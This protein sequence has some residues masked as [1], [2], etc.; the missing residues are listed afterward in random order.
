MQNVFNILKQIE[1]TSSRNE[2]EQILENN[3]QNILFKD[4]IQFIFNPYIVT[5]ISSKKI[6]KI[7]TPKVTTQKIN[8]VQDLIKYLSD[9]NTGSD[10]NISQVLTFIQSQLIELQEDYIKLTTKSFKIGITAKTINKT[11]GKNFIPEFNVQ[12]AD[13]YFDCENKVK[14]EFII[15]TK[16]DG[17]RIVAIKQ[18]E[19]NIKFFSRQ[20]QPIEDLVEIE[21]ELKRLPVGYVYDGELL[22]TNIEKL[23]SK[24][25]YRKTMQIG[26]KDGIKKGLEFHMFDIITI[27]SFTKGIDKTP[28]FKRKELLHNILSKLDLKHIVEVSMLYQGEDKE[29]VIKLLNE[30][31]ARDE[32]GVMLNLSN[33][34]YE[35]KRSKGILKVKVMQ[36]SDL[37]V[38]GFEEGD[39]KLK[40]SLGRI[41]VKFKNNIVGVGSGFSEK[42][43]KEIFN[44]QDK[45]INKIAKIQ[46]FEVSM[47]EKTQLESLRFPVFIEWRFDIIEPSYY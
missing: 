21:E 42:M 35:C 27:D 17:N 24:D 44:N 18:S 30:A 31:K 33:A 4:I 10:E 1:L 46:Y 2:K 9:N 6:K 36:D 22:A 3:K 16:L 37:L 7:K 28:C 32:E 29:M 25:L 47:N 5:G 15:T 20:G 8:T 43:R 38:V 19:S 26:R 23:S 41:N 39:G 13:K 34:P 45:Y 12:L 11:F 14:G 40:G